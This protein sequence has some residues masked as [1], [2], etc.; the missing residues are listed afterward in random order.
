[1]GEADL[2]EVATAFPSGE[3]IDGIYGWLG[4]IQFKDLLCA[5]GLLAVYG[6]IAQACSPRFDPEVS[7]EVDDVYDNLA[8]NIQRSVPHD[9][10]EFLSTLM[11]EEHKL[12]LLTRG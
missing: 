5:A 8:M 3:G 12:F 6:E 11:V 1:M 10:V 2:Y 4:Y 7:L 9:E